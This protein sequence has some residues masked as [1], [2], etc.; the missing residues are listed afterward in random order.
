MA[1]TYIKRYR[2]EIGLLGR[3]LEAAAPAGFE[4]LPWHPAL[5]ELHARGKYLSFREE[6][7]ANVFPCLGEFEGCRRLMGEIARKPGFLPQ[8]T[9]LAARTPADAIGWVGPAGRPIGEVCGTVQGIRD[10]TG[11]GAIQNLGVVP[12]CRGSGLGTCLLLA[13]L[14]G[15]RQAGLTR[16]FLEVTA[17]N[18]GAIRL[19]QRHGFSIQKTIFKAAEVA[20]S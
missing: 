9:W 17:E 1:L 18:D 20:F 10:L 16:A 4:M 5:L 15:F 19:Y 7:D 3:R 2:M 6:I 8:A 12:A 14:Q 13:A 11:L